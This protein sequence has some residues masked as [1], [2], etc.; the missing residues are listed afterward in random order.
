M[1]R[2]AYRAGSLEDDERAQLEAL[3]VCWSI[4]KRFSWQDWYALACEYYTVNGN[5]KVPLEYRTD[6]GRKLGRWICAQRDRYYNTED[7]WKR[8]HGKKPLDDWQ[9]DQMTKIGMVW[10]QYRPRKKQK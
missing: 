2:K 8:R 1:Q 10:T 6:T 4:Q 7:E 3:G 9:I 5:L